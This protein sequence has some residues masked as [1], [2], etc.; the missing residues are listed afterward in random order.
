VNPDG[1]NLVGFEG[2]GLGGGRCCDWSPDGTRSL[3]TAAR[4]KVYSVDVD[5][6]EVRLL[7]EVG[8]ESV[9]TARWS[10][11]GRAVLVRSFPSV[12]VLRLDGS[13]P[14]KLLDGDIGDWGTSPGVTVSESRLEPRW[15]LSR[16]AG[17]LHLRGVASHSATITV[18]VRSPGRTYPASPVPVPPWEYTASVPLPR[19]LLPGALEIVVGGTSGS[20]LLVTVVRPES[21]ESPAT[22]L[23]ARSWMSLTRRGAPRA[24]VRVAPRGS[25][26]S[27]PSPC[28]PLQER[29]SAQSGSPPQDP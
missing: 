15:V 8:G 27:S 19:D 18:T 4:T 7:G 14:V 6:G 22:G 16:Q 25:L 17:R 24:R 10:P 29:G 2:S 5:D 28:G 1:T 26:R 12:Y 13:A 23:V 20:E 3:L 21:L 11:D 9:S